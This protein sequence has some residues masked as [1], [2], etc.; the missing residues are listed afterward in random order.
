[1]V[2]AWMADI[3]PD[4]TTETVAVAVGEEAV[5]VGRLPVALPPDAPLADA[6]GAETGT[7]PS[8]PVVLASPPAAALASE[9]L[10]VSSE[11]VAVA[12]PAT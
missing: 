4:A 3:T 1:M 2:K 8:D 7:L 6:A 5:I 10:M 9:R 12:L 11:P